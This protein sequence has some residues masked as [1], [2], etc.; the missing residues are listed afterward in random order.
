MDL[1]WLRITLRVAA[2]VLL[3]VTVV[4]FALGDLSF[5]MHEDATPPGYV[6][7]NVIV[8]AH[9]PLILLFLSAIFLVLSFVIPPKRV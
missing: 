2:A 9:I 1:R 4:R 3:V 7:D 5:H 6:V 8:I